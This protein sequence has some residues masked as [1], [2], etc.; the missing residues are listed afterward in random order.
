[1][2]IGAVILS[3]YN[4][5]RLPGKA[6]MML[7][8]KTVIETIVERLT[9]VLDL[10][11]IVI[12]TSVEDTDN[13]IVE[14]AHNKGFN[15]YRGSLENVAE[16]FY[17]AAKKQDWDY[18]IR[19]NG[20][21]V[22]VDIKLLQQMI[23]VAKNNNYDFL[24]NVKDR[25]YPKGMS[26]EIV[27]LNYYKNLLEII[28][29]SERYKEHVTLYLYENENIKHYYFYNTKLPEAAGIQLALDTKEDFERTKKIMSKFAEN[30]TK[31]NLKDIFDIYKKLDL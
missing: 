20:D 3:R 22:F 24:S 4:S 13:P 8:G 26:I 31:Y 27:N 30:H 11:D 10:D 17:L 25:T 7:N 23:D 1:M 16:R 29:S 21:N 9:Q 18:A 15:I 19:I 14:F 28:N 6:L 5:M 12:A 2:K